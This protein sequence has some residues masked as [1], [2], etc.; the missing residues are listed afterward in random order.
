MSVHAKQILIVWTMLCFA[1]STIE[2]PKIVRGVVTDNIE[3]SESSDDVLQS[4]NSE[5]LYDMY[6]NDAADEETLWQGGGSIRFW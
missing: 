3:G 6:H 4:E 2:R 5:R 1:Y